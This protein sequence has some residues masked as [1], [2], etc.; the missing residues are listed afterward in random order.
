MTV[1]VLAFI[2]QAKAQSQPPSQV[3]ITITSHASSSTA[4]SKPE[5]PSVSFD[6][7]KSLII[8][9]SC[10]A[11]I[12]V[13]TIVVCIIRKISNKRRKRKGDNNYNDDSHNGDGKG[14]NGHNQNNITQQTLNVTSP[15]LPF[16]PFIV[17]SKGEE[18]KEVP[19]VASETD[20]ILKV[21]SDNDS[22]DNK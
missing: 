7:L 12:V 11:G 8:V 17:D 2:I 4:S 19:K 14:Q 3:V 5:E 18:E 20:V 9:A 1:V 15:G 10:V 16:L 21:Q 22:S 13:I 6:G